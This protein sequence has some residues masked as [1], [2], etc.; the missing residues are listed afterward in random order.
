MINYGR[1]FISKDDINLINKVIRSN[2]LT[3]GPFVNLFENKLSSFFKSRF[4]STVSN[5]TAALY[6]SGK[7]LNWKPNDIILTTPITFVATANA[8]VLNGS[9]PDFVDINLNNYSLDLNKL[10]D[11]I[12]NY[13]KKNKRIKTVIVVDY[14][15]QPSD[16]SSIKKLADKYQFSTINDNCHSIGS[17]YKNDIGYAAK[18]ADLVTHSYH[19]VKNITTGEGGAILTN[20]KDYYKKISILKNHGLEKK[21][22]LKSSSWKFSLSDVSHNFR[23]SDISCALGFSQLKQL[24]KFIKRRREISNLYNKLFLNN[25]NIITPPINK[26]CYNSYH[27]YPIRIKT[28]NLR[29][30][31]KNIVSRLNN[32]NFFP[33]I[34][35]FPVYLQPFYKKNFLFKKGYC[36]VAESFFFEELSL[37]IYYGLKNNDI[38]EVANII[39]TFQF[40]KN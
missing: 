28:N 5:G 10:E 17:K 15:G 9:I 27:L 19:P 34:H 4:C 7:V 30:I 3:Q 14:G 35:Y 32:S 1:H 21:N 40:Q 39:N 23:L 36:P 20:N 33:Q 18:Y 2:F 12:K 38:Y 29:N 6:L 25:H 13:K 37:P 11:K 26:D 31:K 8:I 16:W 22:L 24:N